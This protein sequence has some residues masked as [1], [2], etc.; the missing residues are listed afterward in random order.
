MILELQDSSYAIISSLMYLDT[1][2]PFP[3]YLFLL[4]GACDLL[5][6]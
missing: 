2:V 4:L 3:K 1:M 5:V 6:A